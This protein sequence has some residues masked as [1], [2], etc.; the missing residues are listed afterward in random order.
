MEKV[1]YYAMHVYREG[2]LHLTPG[3]YESIYAM[4]MAYGAKYNLDY[5]GNIAYRG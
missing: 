1:C 5:I 2:N 3:E 4:A